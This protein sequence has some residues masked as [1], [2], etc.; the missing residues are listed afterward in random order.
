MS[1]ELDRMSTEALQPLR[2]PLKRRHD[3]KAKATRPL[4]LYPDATTADVIKMVSELEDQLLVAYPVGSV[5]PQ[6]GC[7]GIR[8][9][10]SGRSAVT[11]PRG[12][13]R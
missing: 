1:R 8:T 10:G 4:P 12:R 5:A 7:G 9:A 13:D 6:H 2:D 11:R 3:T